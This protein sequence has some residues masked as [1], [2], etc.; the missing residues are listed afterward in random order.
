VPNSASPDPTP[1]PSPI[2]PTSAPTPNDPTPSPIVPTPAPN[3]PPTGGGGGGVGC[4]ADYQSVVT[5]HNI[6]KTIRDLKIGDMVI[7]DE[8]LQEYIG[9]IHEGSVLPTLVLHTT[10]RSIE[11][12]GNHLV[13][14][15]VG[16]SHASS[17][18]VGDFIA[19]GKV[20]RITRATSFVSSPLTRS[21]TIVVNDIMLSCYASVYSHK[22]AK[23]VTYPL[24]IGVF[25]SINS[26]FRYLIYI[27][28]I[29]PHPVKLFIA[30]DF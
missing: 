18:I 20:V 16:F 15:R 25:K 26:Y 14:T 23:M 29:L 5:A 4:I 11:I 21:G 6:T 13:K 30:S 24:R 12:T 9:N 2:V 1:S 19:T 8:G 3:P 10:N 17:I 27:H 7:T 28:K 22:I